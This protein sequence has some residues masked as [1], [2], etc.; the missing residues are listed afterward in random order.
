MSHV[1]Y[2]TCKSS[3]AV[4]FP[5]CAFEIAS[6]RGITNSSLLIINCHDW[7]CNAVNYTDQQIREMP[8]WITAKKETL[9]K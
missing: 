2:I 3:H 5:P 6:S 7:H 4:S 8:G 9:S 1:D